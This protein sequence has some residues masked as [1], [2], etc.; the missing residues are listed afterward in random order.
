MGKLGYTLTAF[1]FFF[2]SVIIISNTS[3]TIYTYMKEKKAHDANYW[4]S[5]TCLVFAILGL[6]ISGFI[7]YKSGKA[8]FQAYTAKAGSAAVPVVAAVPQAQ[9]VVLPQPPVVVAQ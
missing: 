2:L 6:I 1:I 9:P 4:W 3:I 8:N 5:V 7:F